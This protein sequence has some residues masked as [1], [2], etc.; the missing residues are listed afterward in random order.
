M[1]YQ[2]ESGR[3]NGTQIFVVRFYF[4]FQSIHFKKILVN[5]IEVYNYIKSHWNKVVHVNS[6]GKKPKQQTNKQK[7]LDLQEEN[8]LAEVLAFLAPSD[9]EV[10]MKQLKAEDLHVQNDTIS[11]LATDLWLKINA[12]DL[13]KHVTLWLPLLLQT[14]YNDEVSCVKANTHP[15]MYQKGCLL[16]G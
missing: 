1:N 4:H 15:G 9:L 12:Y 10:Q 7:I 2:E 6:W 13:V 14:S 8:L 3:E 5:K 16:E 11:I